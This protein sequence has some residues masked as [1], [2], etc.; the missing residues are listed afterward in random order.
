MI[1]LLRDKICYNPTRQYQDWTLISDEQT[2]HDQ[3]H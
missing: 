2:R 1:M 3:R